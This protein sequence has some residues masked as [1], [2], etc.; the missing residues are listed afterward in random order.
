MEKITQLLFSEVVSQ[1]GERLGR[2]FDVRCQ[3]EPEHGDSRE[4]RAA[5]ELV[6][7]KRG[8]LEVLGF[9]KAAGKRVGWAA[10]RRIE[11]GRIVIDEAG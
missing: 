4:E 7:G 9:K 8:L 10:V 6:Y 5:S 2:V 3:G 11:R 1:D